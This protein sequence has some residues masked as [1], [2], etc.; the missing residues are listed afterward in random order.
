MFTLTRW[1][2]PSSI[3]SME[4]TLFY[5][6]AQCACVALACIYWSTAV[7]D[8]FNQVMSYITRP[9]PVP[10]PVVHCVNNKLPRMIRVNGKVVYRPETQKGLRVRGRNGVLF[11]S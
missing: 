10:D 11:F 7:T 9:L 3:G 2:W 5:A 8:L 4:G 1:P 6:I